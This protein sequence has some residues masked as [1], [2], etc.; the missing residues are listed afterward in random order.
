MS[1]LSSKQ[2]VELNGRLVLKLNGALGETGTEIVHPLPTAQ[3]GKLECR[4]KRRSWVPPEGNT[5][6]LA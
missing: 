4:R 1:D 5:R 2:V 3:F 6:R